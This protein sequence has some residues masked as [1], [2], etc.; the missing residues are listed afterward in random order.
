[1][2]GAASSVAARPPQAGSSRIDGVPVVLVLFG[3][4][5][6]ASVAAACRRAGA[7]TRLVSNLADARRSTALFG[8]CAAIVVEPPSLAG[9]FHT[10]LRVLSRQGAVLVAGVSAGTKERIALLNSGVDCVLPRIDPDEVVAALAAV[11]RRSSMPTPRQLSEVLCAGEIRVQL[12]H[13]TAT[14]AGRR[15]ILTPLEFDLLAYF[16]AHAGVPLSRDR[17]LENVWGYDI[18]GRGTVTVH[19]RRL[20]RKLEADPAA[21][22]RLQTV[23]GIGYRL[24]P[25][26]A[27]A[28]G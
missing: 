3:G 6:G 24:D 12:A 21:P 9:S 17:L 14:A 18:G 20:R 26:A 22:T 15:L 4:T 8:P 2:P 27:Q 23:W 28:A 10:G 11:V 25:D 13:R 1:M 16:V 19:V 7:I 5:S